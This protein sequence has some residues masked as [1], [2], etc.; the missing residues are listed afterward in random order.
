MI[1]V[2]V[3]FDPT[4]R[5]GVKPQAIASTI[6]TGGLVLRIADLNH[7]DRLGGRGVFVKID[8]AARLPLRTAA[9]STAG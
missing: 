5:I 8:S 2:R 1:V 6:D 4:E 9:S 7:Q 3:C